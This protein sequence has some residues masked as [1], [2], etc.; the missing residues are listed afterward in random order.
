MAP[1][2]Q[3]PTHHPQLERLL[4]VMVLSLGFSGARMVVGQQTLASS[5]VFWEGFALAELGLFDAEYNERGLLEVYGGGEGQTL[6]VHQ[7]ACLEDFVAL[8]SDLLALEGTQVQEQVYASAPLAIVVVDAQGRVESLNPAAQ[9]LWECGPLELLPGRAIEWLADSDDARAQLV[10]ALRAGETVL[11]F[12]CASQTVRGSPLQLNLNITPVQDTGGQTL[13][14]VCCVEEV[15]ARQR[16]QDQLEGQKQFYENILDHIPTEI[17]VLDQNLRYLYINP[18][19]IKDPELRAWS[20]GKTDAEIMERTAWKPDSLLER[21]EKLEQMVQDKVPQVWEEAFELKGSWV[22]RQ[23]YANPVMDASGALKFIVG[24]SADITALKER[25]LAQKQALEEYRSLFEGA[26]VGLYRA[27]IHGKLLTANPALV[28]LSGYPTAEAYLH[29]VNEKGRTVFVSRTHRQKVIQTLMEGGTVN[30]WRTQILPL[31]AS[32]PRWVSESAH[33]VKAKSGEVLYYEGTARDV[34]DEM[35]ALER[36]QLIEHAVESSSDAITLYDPEFR[37]IYHNPAAALT[38]GRNIDEFNR[39]MHGVLEH[40]RVALLITYLKTHL[41]WKGELEVMHSEGRAVPC[42]VRL[43]TILGSEGERL[44]TLSVVTDISLRREVEQ[45]KD[46]FITTV[47]HELRTPLTSLRGALGLLAGDIWGEPKS[48][49]RDLIGIALSNTERLS[50]R[51]SDILDIGNLESG[52]LYLQNRPLE[53]GALLEGAAL[54]LTGL[55]SER[56][57]R[58]SLNVLEEIQVSGDSERLMQVMI[59]LLSNAAKASPIGGDVS[60]RIVRQPCSVRLEVRDGGPGIS[61]EFAAHIFRRFARA[62]TSNTREH[63]GLGLG[64]AIS[65]AIVERH[66][67]LIGFE[68]LQEGGSLFFVELPLEGGEEVRL[69]DLADLI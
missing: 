59:H 65:K 42:Q 52:R 9:H 3:T 46:D 28:R 24:Y 5:G 47:S 64:L 44:G 60:A 21:R 67:G 23:R 13:R 45:I 18:E 63:G 41:S 55:Y 36:L 10:R 8:A 48:A 2:P 12:R 33:A 40:G 35:Q 22:Y 49:A 66:G 68:Q 54:E 26:Q 6:S 31:G 57:V 38:F 43:D 7:Q 11:N 51:I 29:A 25:K 56:K 58:L 20:L 69:E 61:N 32:S 19:A 39:D 17:G 53:L 1:T 27:D 16:L 30:E 14:F 4:K 37:A 62:D 50:R 15:S 34:H